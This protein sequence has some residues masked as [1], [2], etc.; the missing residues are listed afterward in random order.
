MG[1]WPHLEQSFSGCKASSHCWRWDADRVRNCTH[2][3]DELDVKFVKF[4]HLNNF[5][6]HIRQLGNVLNV[7]SEFPEGAMLDLKQAYQ[8]S[9]WHEAAFQILWTK[10]RKEVFQYREVN[11]NAAKQCRKDDIPLTKAPI[12]R[13]MKTPQPEIKTL[14]DLAEWCAM[15]KGKLQNHIA[16]CVKRFADFTENINHHHYFSRRKDAKYIRYNPVAIPVTTFQCDK[17][18]V[19]MVRCTGCTK[20][21]KPKPPRNDTVLLWM[22]MSLDSHF[23]WTAARIPAR[24]QCL[25]V[26]EDAEWSVEGHPALVQTIATEPI[27]L[28]A[29]VVIG[30]ER[31]QTLMQPV[32]DGCSCW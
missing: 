7:S 32:R 30:V 24:L 26:V 29:G 10:A 3:V 13:M 9:N 25:F 11:A 19:H 28:T 12:K 8:Q 5:S 31:H 1:G 22:G 20:W 18:A 6:D 27:C 21:R 23:R 16:W 14:D 15:P 17:E 4:H 2:L